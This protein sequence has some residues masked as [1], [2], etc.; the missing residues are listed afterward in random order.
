MS[1]E[2]LKFPD[3]TPAQQKLQVE[4]VEELKPFE[5]VRLTGDTY[6]KFLSTLKNC[7]GFWQVQTLHKHFKGMLDQTVTEG[8]LLNVSWLV[9]GNYSELFRDNVLQFGELNTLAWELAEVVDVNT[10]RKDQQLMQL[11]Q[12]RILTGPLASQV[13]T[14]YWSLK[15]TSYLATYRDEKNYGFGFSRSR[16]NKK[17]EELSHCIFSHVRQFFKLRCYLL[18][19][20]ER[21]NTLPYVKEVGHRNGT[22]GYNRKLIGRRDR[23]L[24]SCLK[25]LPNNPEC[26]QCPY[27]LDHCELATHER[28]YK[29]G[30][31]SGCG[32]LS[33]FDPT[34]ISRCIVCV[35]QEL[36]SR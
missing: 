8:D 12:F 25:Q 18:L 16:I 3:F 4:L 32:K 15:K 29:K 11:F 19:D 17:G 27:G 28:T 23:S 36:K 5:G 30:T 24:Q 10:V 2:H 31:C 6:V 13:I 26:Y 7:G 14:N 35:T 22:M 33:F 1:Q 20:P 9:A 34:D 21:S